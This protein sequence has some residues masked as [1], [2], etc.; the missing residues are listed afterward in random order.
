MRWLARILAAAVVALTAQAAQAQYLPPMAH[1]RAAGPC[2]PILL[3][4]H[5]FGGSHRTHPD[6]GAA[7]AAAGFDTWVIGHVESG[8]A[9]WKRVTAAENANAAIWKEILDPTFNHRHLATIEVVRDHVVGL[10]DCK[11]PMVVLGGFSVGAQVTMVEAG[12]KTSFGVTGR[13]GFDAYI[14]LSPPGIGPQFPLESWAPIDKPVLVVTGTHDGAAFQTW[15]NRLAVFQSLPE[16]GKS[17]FVLLR[18]GKH[19]DM[20]GQGDEA[21]PRRVRD[22]VSDYLVGLRNTIPAMRSTA[23][24]E[25][26]RR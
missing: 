15:K 14:A 7:A 19:L 20:M 21:V 13:G 6:L 17:R 18:N 16:T 12:A 5:G 26:W 11:P 10:R 4:S 1:Y 8:P 3:F 9:A 25:V 23:W 24:Q 22:I 2:P